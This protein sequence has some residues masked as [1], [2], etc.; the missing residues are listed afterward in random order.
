[1]KTAQIRA[2]IKSWE[3]GCL[4]VDGFPDG[5]DRQWKLRVLDFIEHGIK[6]HYNRYFRLSTSMRT[7]RFTIDDDN[8]S[9]SEQ[10]VLFNLN[11]D[12]LVR[13]AYIPPLVA[14]KGDVQLE[15]ELTVED[16]LPTFRRFLHH[17]WKMTQPEPIPKELLLSNDQFVAPTLTNMDRRNSMRA[18]LIESTSPVMKA[19]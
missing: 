4:F 5:V 17:L 6:Q 8:R 18:D 2:N 15:Y 1:V 3:K 14:T 11:N 19:L 10:C 7:L 16:A 12:Q 9:A 13:L